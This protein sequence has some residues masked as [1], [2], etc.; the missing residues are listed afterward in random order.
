MTQRTHYDSLFFSICLFLLLSPASKSEL[1][2]KSS[3]NNSQV[4]TLHEIALVPGKHL[5][6]KMI[7]NF[8]H[9]GD[10]VFLLDVPT[11]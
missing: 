8:K 1:Q 7:V 9:G 4:D 6:Q 3:R 5:V 10:Y 2:P 11:V